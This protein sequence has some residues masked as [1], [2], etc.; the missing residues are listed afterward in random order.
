LLVKGSDE[1]KQ[2]IENLIQIIKNL[3]TSF[4]QNAETLEEV[5]QLLSSKIEESWH[6]HS[7]P[8]NITR[9]SKAWWNKEC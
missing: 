5:V 6:E 2:F 9:Y 7:K 1:E 3:N 8:V 4:I